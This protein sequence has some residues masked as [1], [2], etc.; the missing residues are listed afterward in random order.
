VS[1]AKIK[2]ASWAGRRA[3][4]SFLFGGCVIFFCIYL[5]F[6][7][8]F[9]LFFG[10]KEKCAKESRREKSFLFPGWCCYGLQY[11]CAAG[12]IGSDGFYF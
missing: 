6:H 11:Y 1:P 3:F 9:T 5:L 12:L 4:I 8:V 2:A 10:G 7:R